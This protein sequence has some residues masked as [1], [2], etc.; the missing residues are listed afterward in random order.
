MPLASIAA[1]MGGEG[2]HVLRYWERGRGGR[3]DTDD[4]SVRAR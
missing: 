4:K 2:K 3:G 1:R